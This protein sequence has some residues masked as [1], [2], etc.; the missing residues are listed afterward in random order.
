MYRS[1]FGQTPSLSGQRS[2]PKTDE[3][4]RTIALDAPLAEELWQ[5][6]RR[7]SYGEPGDLVFCHPHK[8]THVPSGYFAAIMKTVLA[9]AGVDRPMRDSTTGGT[10]ASRTRRRRGWSR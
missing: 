10:P 4:E 7:S 5:H 1:S 9:R 2:D 3:G 8:G 6:R